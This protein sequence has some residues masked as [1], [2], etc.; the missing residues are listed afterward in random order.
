MGSPW[1]GTPNFKTLPLHVTTFDKTSKA[2]P[3]LEPATRRR[4]LCR[5]TWVTSGG[6]R[7]RTGWQTLLRRQS[8][9]NSSHPIRAI[10]K[11]HH[12]VLLA[13][14]PVVSCSPHGKLRFSEIRQSSFHDQTRPVS[15]RR[16]TPGFDS[17]G[18]RPARTHPGPSRSITGL[19]RTR[20]RG[21]IPD[22]QTPRCRL[23]DRSL[24]NQCMRCPAAAFVPVG[25]Y[26]F[27]QPQFYL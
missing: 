21:A 15:H 24:I 26:H 14:F 4:V 9:L 8:H 22:Q 19:G 1:S 16:I 25:A 27:Y 20:G 3:V 5:V 7:Q 23:Q 13:W 11:H 12:T 2:A 18:S 6:N 10:D 17:A